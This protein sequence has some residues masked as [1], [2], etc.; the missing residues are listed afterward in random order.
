MYILSG[1]YSYSHQSPVPAG[2]PLTLLRKS[3]ARERDV[4]GPLSLLT[5]EA[6]EVGHLLLNTSP[7]A[8]PHEPGV[9][10]ST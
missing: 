6:G 3:W 10:Q 5:R 2:W 1:S 4:G 8:W 7:V 9:A